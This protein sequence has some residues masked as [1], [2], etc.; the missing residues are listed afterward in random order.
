MTTFHIWP[1]EPRVR[2]GFV[3]S[4]AEIEDSTIGRETLWYRYP[5]EHA[6]SLSTSCDH[7]VVGSINLLMRAGHPVEVHGVVSPSLLKNLQEFQSAW[8]AWRDE[9]KQVEITADVECEPAAKATGLG[10]LVAFSGGVDS[11]FSAFRNS[12]LF[13]GRY[14][15]PLKAA[16]MVHG[17]D[18]PLEETNTFASAACRSSAVLQSLELELIP[19]ATNYRT[20]VEDWSHSFGAAV[21]SCLMALS[22]SYQEGLIGQG[23]AYEHLVHFGEGSNPLT[24]PLLSSDSFKVIPDGA[25]FVR[26]DKIWMMRD[27]G[28]FLENVRVCWAGPIKDRNCCECEKCIR[29]ILTFRVLGLGLPQAFEK[30]VP[31]KNIDEL[32]RI[33]E[34]IMGTQYDEIVCLARE[35]QI[36]GT[37]VDV[38]ERRL[39]KNRRYRASK[40]RQRV[41]RFPYYARRAWARV[42]GS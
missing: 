1:Q 20:L 19:A 30:D 11:S 29:N 42:I 5:E 32:K 22:G 41:A 16:V 3:V 15:R 4:A 18:I 8:A 33:N 9:L 38:L 7:F 10:A 28:S 2:D 26:A 17:F 39:K 6:P 40:V 37:W 24:D 25:G 14:R 34:I 23:I 12:S 13:G 27:W 35:A 36:S 21:A 31:D